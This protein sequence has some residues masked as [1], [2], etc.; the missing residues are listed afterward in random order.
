[1]Q[2]PCSP[3]CA[4]QASSQSDCATQSYE[5]LVPILTSTA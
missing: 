3:A 4:K 1:M 5:A 2:T